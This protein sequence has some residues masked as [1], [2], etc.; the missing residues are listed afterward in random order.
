VR[1][2]ILNK[3]PQSVDIVLLNAAGE[4]V[5]ETLAPK[6]KSRVLL[7]ERIGPLTHTLVKKGHLRL[8]RVS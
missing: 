7:S 4:P 5:Y 1:V 6:A 8:Q 3:L 2:I